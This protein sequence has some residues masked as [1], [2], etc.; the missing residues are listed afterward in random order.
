MLDDKDKKILEY[1]GRNVK[2]LQV[3]NRINSLHFKGECFFVFLKH[4][5]YGPIIS[6]EAIPHVCHGDE[7]CA[8]WRETDIFP[9]NI[10]QY[11]VDRIVIPGSSS[12]LELNPEKVLIDSTRITFTIPDV[13]TSSSRRRINRNQCQRDMSASIVQAGISFSCTLVDY[14]PEGMKVTICAEDLENTY[15]LN[16][17]KDVSLVVTNRRRIIFSGTCAIIREEGEKDTKNLVLFPTE[18]NVP[19]YKPKK[20]RAKRFIVTPALDVEFINPLTSK[21]VKLP[22]RDISSLGLSVHESE[23]SSLLFC[24]LILENIR[25]I[26]CESKFIDIRGQVVY[27]RNEATDKIVCGIAILDITIEDHLKL[28]ALVH[29]AEDGSSYVGINYDADKFFDFLFD[30]G[31]IYSGKYQEL[32]EYKKE[33]T[34]VYKKLY[35]SHNRIARCFVH[36]ENGQITGHVSALRIYKY[37]W[38]NHH[39]AATSKKQSGLKV[40]RQIS[41]FHNDSYV[42]NPLYMRYIVGIW[43]PDNS[44]PAR[45]FGSFAKNLND[46]EMCSM[47]T[48]TY[49]HLDL[50]SNTD[51]GELCGPWVISL[52]DK[53]D[54]YE[55]S[56]YYSRVSNGLLIRAYDLIP[57]R[58]RDDTIKA[59]YELCALRRE[60]FLYTIRYGH[61]M[62]ALIDLQCSDHGLNLSDLTN[63]IYVYIMREDML[64]APTI[65]SI[66]GALARKHNKGSCPLML[67]PDTYQAKLSGV[68]TKKY[69]VWILNTDCSD[70]YMKHIERWCR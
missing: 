58:F 31:F 20:K 2:R 23:E 32:S 25:I 10:Y 69:T 65:F 60:R 67:F 16:T 43:R 11:A 51:I 29:K 14:S 19:R 39:H 28:I 55:F 70:P 66:C 18:M 45:F 17:E 52:S 56:G 21:N 1:P 54:M 8:S 3:A 22:V 36:L 13:I 44:F 35:L 5:E 7:L 34:D 61:E 38:L 64:E 6:L 26:S 37:T 41:D 57:D 53:Q 30:S 63:A 40:L 49:C 62:V 59:E 46:L 68:K 15:W 12:S 24:G 42:L 50:S 33:F 27:R 4:R 9:K 47:D 48:F